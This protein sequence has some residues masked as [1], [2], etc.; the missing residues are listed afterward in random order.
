MSLKNFSIFISAILFFLVFLHHSCIKAKTED[1][2]SLP[3]TAKLIKPNFVFEF[4]IDEK[5][6]F[7]DVFANLNLYTYMAVQNALVFELSS[8]DSVSQKNVYTFYKLKLNDV[9][10][11]PN[12]K[13]SDSFNLLNANT[14][15]SIHRLKT[16]D[17][18]KNQDNFCISISKSAYSIYSSILLP[19]NFSFKL[20]TGLQKL[21]LGVVYVSKN[22]SNYYSLYGYD[23]D[24]FELQ[25]FDK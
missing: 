17:T 10:G 23:A 21:K 25:F 12:T 3:D 1:H 6:A 14:I 8:Y 24:D 22:N 5:M 16:M 2:Y 15:Y 19:Y 9:P 18:T 11:K 20:Q 4:E 13:V 7:N